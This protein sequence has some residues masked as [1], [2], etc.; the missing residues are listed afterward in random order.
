MCVYSDSALFCG[1]LNSRCFCVCK[2]AALSSPLG[3]FAYFFFLLFV[4][5]GVRIPV[6]E[7]VEMG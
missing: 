5:V 1:C 2:C 6:D 3:F 4:Y 7:N